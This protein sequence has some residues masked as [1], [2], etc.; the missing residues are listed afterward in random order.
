MATAQWGG[1]LHNK[2][3]GLSLKTTE[4]R[5]LSRSRSKNHLRRFEWEK[6]QTPPAGP[7]NHQK[8]RIYT[9]W[10]MCD[11]YE[12]KLYKQHTKMLRNLTFRT[13]R[14]RSLAMQRR[15][16]CF[17][18]KRTSDVRNA[19]RRFIHNELQSSAGGHDGQISSNI[20][21]DLIVASLIQVSNMTTD[22]I[23]TPS[24]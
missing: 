17:G 13:S 16:I 21:T 18:Q 8:Y 24:L 20:R 7:I 12:N 2:H 11:V 5:M 3:Q 6:L 9:C 15:Q 10:Q 22:Y 19:E 4:V 23:Y 14:V 1:T